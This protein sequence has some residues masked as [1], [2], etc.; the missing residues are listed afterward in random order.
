MERSKE[1]AENVY[2][3][4]SA[5]LPVPCDSKEVLSLHFLPVNFVP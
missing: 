4:R 5:S 2:S 3:V 1:A